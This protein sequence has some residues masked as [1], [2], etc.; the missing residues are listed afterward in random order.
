MR[1][2]TAMPLP[3]GKCKDKQ[4]Y[5][6]EKSHSITKKYRKNNH[7]KIVGFFVCPDHGV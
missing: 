7:M 1:V 3:V 2:A 6:Y 4:Y 5:N